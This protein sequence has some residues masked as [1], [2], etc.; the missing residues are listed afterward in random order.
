MKSMKLNAY[1]SNCIEFG[2][3]GN[4]K[5][6]IYQLDLSQYSIENCDLAQGLTMNSPIG[7]AIRFSG[8]IKWKSNCDY[9]SVHGE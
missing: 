6:S 9:I 3:I 2:G 5:H 7:T 8:C 4:C 1:R